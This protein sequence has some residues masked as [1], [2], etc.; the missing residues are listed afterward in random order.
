MKRKP[1]GG[2]FAMAQFLLAVTSVLLSP[3]A[4]KLTVV[5]VVGYVLEATLRR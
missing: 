5:F 4:P 1:E 3:F 2:A